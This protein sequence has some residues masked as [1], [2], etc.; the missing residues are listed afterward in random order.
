MFVQISP[1]EQDM[2]ETLSSLNFAT[3]VQGVELG[4]AKRQ[5]D[6]GELQKMKMM[7]SSK[8]FNCY[9]LLVNYVLDAA[10]WNRLISFIYWYGASD[11]LKLDKAKQE[12]N[13]KDEALRKLEEKIQTLEGKAKSKDHNCKNQKEKVNELELHLE[14]RKELCRQLEKQLL[15]LSEEMKKEEIGLTLHQKVAS[16]MSYFFFTL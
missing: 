12:S 14:S 7:V 9:V 10:A 6:L 11:F 13:S 15:Q 2:S 3:R 5:I 4:P 1:S 8:L 16:L